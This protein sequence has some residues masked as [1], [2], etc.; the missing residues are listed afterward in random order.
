MDKTQVI[1]NFSLDGDEFSLDDVT[2][3]LEVTHT[4]THKKGDLIQNCSTACY[5]KETS[6]DLGTGYQVSLM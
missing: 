3:K 1:V 5:R 4:E 2:E 6:W